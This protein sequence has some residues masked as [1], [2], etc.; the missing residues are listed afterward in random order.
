MISEWR[1]GFLSPYRKGFQAMRWLEGK[2]LHITLIPP[3]YADEKEIGQVI[4]AIEAVAAKNRGFEVEFRKIT[5]G[6]DPRRPRL[7]WAEGPTPRQ[8]TALKTGLENALDAQKEKRLFTP[9]LTLARFRPENFSSFP[10]KKLDEKIVWRE[11]VED[12]L[13]MESHLSASGADYE[14]IAEIALS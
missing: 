12:V 13:L 10:V 4:T 9:H 11:N 7:I 8:L 14:I 5:Y 2:N 6:P 1:E 3:W